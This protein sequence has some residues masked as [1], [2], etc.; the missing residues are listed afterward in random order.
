[1]VADARAGVVAGPLRVSASVGV[2]PKGA[3]RAALTRVGEG[4]GFKLVSREHWLGLSLADDA[5]LLRA[6]RINVP[7]GYRNPEHIL[8]A[9]VA[10]RTDY[11]EHQQHGVAAAWNGETVRAEVMAILGNYQLHPDV[12]RERGGAGYVEYAFAPNLAAGLS[13]QATSAGAD[14]EQRDTQVLRQSYGLMGRW[15]PTE[16]LSLMGELNGL[17]RSTQEGGTQLG[18]VGYLQANLEVLRG[19]HLI[20]TVEALR[21]DRSGQEGLQLGGWLSGAWFF[22]RGA[23]LRVDGYVRQIPLPTGTSLSTLTALVQLHL[24]L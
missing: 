16:A 24:Y 14:L 1:M 6:G 7:F 9:R 11:N 18:G 12:Y 15:G 4:D 3:R 21:P 22:T 10:T 5:L 13:A 8:W 23:E 20:A 17:V 2:A 19:L